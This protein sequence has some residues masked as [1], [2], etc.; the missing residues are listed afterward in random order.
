MTQSDIDRIESELGVTLPRDYA[1]LLRAH[2]FSGEQDEH[3][4]LDPDYLIE[5]EPEVVHF[6]VIEG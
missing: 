2:K 1:E 5:L 6:E 4:C 3:F